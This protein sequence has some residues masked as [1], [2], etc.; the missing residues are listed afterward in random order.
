MTREHDDHDDFGGLHRDL[1][2]T[3]AAMDRR[4]LFRMAAGFGGAVGALQLFGCGGHSASPT[5]ATSTA[6]TTTTPGGTN[7]ACTAV[8]S[9]TQ[10]PFPGDGSNGPN[11]LPLAGVT[12]SD[13]RSSF[14]GLS[15]NADGVP[16]T[17]ALT[18][19]SK[20]T[21]APLA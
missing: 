7:A 11:V 12:R 6:T 3:G 9:E 14:A 4:N 17:L 8:P 5:A 1:R 21:C 15:G 19:V 2:A 13:I 20:S 16:L 18:I 10:G